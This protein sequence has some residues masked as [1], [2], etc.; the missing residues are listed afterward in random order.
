M[1]DWR[2]SH[3]RGDVMNDDESLESEYEDESLSTEQFEISP[4]SDLSECSS[5]STAKSN[6]SSSRKAGRK[7]VWRENVITDMVDIICS[8]EYLRTNLIFGNT[9]IYTDVVKQLKERLGSRG[10]SFLFDVTQTRN[11][12][13]KCVAECKKATLTIKT[14]TGI[15]RFQ[16]EKNFGEWFSQLYS[17]V[18]TRDSCTPGMALEPSSSH[19]GGSPQT[20]EA[21]ETGANAHSEEINV[22]NDNSSS[23]DSDTGAKAQFVPVKRGKKRL[24]KDP[25]VEAIETMKHVIEKDPTK[26]LLEFFKKENE[27]ARQHEMHLMQMMMA[28]PQCY[29]SGYPAQGAPVSGYDQS[30][31]ASSQQ[32]SFTRSRSP[33]AESSPPASSHVYFTES[34]ESYFS[35]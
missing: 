30:I 13:K 35:L 14:A 6:S 34:D 23:K 1:A 3:T 33:Y 19:S 29:Y 26:E 11:K 15:K 16:E 18:K 8:S 12:L 32:R 17:F 24:K 27:R 2:G 9:A 4:E 28:P 31:R 22:H 7:A 10:E 20:V 5:V 21:T 25:V